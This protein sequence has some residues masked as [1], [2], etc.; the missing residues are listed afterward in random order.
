MWN[1]NNFIYLQLHMTASVIPSKNPSLLSQCYNGIRSSWCPTIIWYAFKA[2][3]NR[4][5]FKNIPSVATVFPSQ[6]LVR[7]TRW[8][9]MSFTSTKL[10]YP[11]V[12]CTS[13]QVHESRA[14]RPNDHNSKPIS[15]TGCSE[16]ALLHT[17]H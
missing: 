12:A 3:T 7:W 4:H 10:L 14:K 13:G 8:K 11:P 17:V 1:I 6:K 5:N 15:S 2:S 16:S 9:L